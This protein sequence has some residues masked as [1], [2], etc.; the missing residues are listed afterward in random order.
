VI[1]TQSIFSG[2]SSNYK[3]ENSETEDEEPNN[4]DDDTDDN[5]PSADGVNIT[6]N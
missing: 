6:L 1:V 5:L 3:P 4:R 2:D